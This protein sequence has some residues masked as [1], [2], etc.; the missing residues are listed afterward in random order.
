MPEAIILNTAASQLDNSVGRETER[1][2]FKSLEGS[3][4]VYIAIQR[5]E[6]AQRQLDPS[7]VRNPNRFKWTP[8]KIQLADGT[9]ETVLVNISSAAKRLNISRSQVQQACA[10]GT[11]DTAV[12]RQ[13]IQKAERVLPYVKLKMSEAHKLIDSL[14]SIR[15]QNGLKNEPILIKTSAARPLLYKDG[16][17]Y[18]LLHEKETDPTLAKGGFKQLKQ[19]VE[20]ESGE[21]YALLTSAID[22]AE[23]RKIA[24]NEGEILQ[25][26]NG[27]EGFPLTYG[28]I[29]LETKE[30]PKHLIL[31]QF[32]EQGSLK[33]L[34]E[35]PKPDFNPNRLAIA[36]D[37]LK[38]LASLDRAN[39]IHRDIKPDNILL[40][41]KNGQV[42]AVIS[43]F[44]LSI[45]KEQAQRSSSGTPKYLAPEKV[46]KFEKESEKSDVWAMGLTLFELCK[47][48]LSVGLYREIDQL[49]LQQRIADGI[50]FQGFMQGVSDR[51]WLTEPREENSLDHLIWSM[52]RSKPKDR[53]RAAEAL[54]KFRRIYPG[55]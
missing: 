33:D 54:E 4:S 47:M 12:S 28:V 2:V 34:I 23:H 37:L 29:E 39:L 44:G 7:L 24:Q 13:T 41:R 6:E 8:L 46:T 19:A 43:D 53:I 14:E 27:E 17:F 35:D 51:E 18:L 32:Y 3:K 36:E 55:L 11:L 10:N 30:G 21:V 52:L 15:Q 50:Y 40:T 22:D 31:Q 5:L 48:Q 45:K 42:R 25:S 16:K 1:V 49:F 9:L 20:I 26:L 38:G